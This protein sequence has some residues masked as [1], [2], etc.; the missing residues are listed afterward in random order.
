MAI[1]FHCVSCGKPIEVDDGWGGRLVQCPY[2]RDTVTAPAFSAPSSL[3]ATRSDE[4]ASEPDSAGATLPPPRPLPGTAPTQAFPAPN[5]S[6]PGTWGTPPEPDLRRGNVL[7][8]VAFILALVAALLGIGAVMGAMAA[9]ANAIG[10][11]PKPDEVGKFMEQAMQEGAPWVVKVSLAM[12]GGCGLW[13]AGAICGIIAVFRRPRGLAIA[14]LV[15]CAVPVLL[16]FLGL[17]MRGV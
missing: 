13:L 12:M 6:M 3:A 11:N 4:R 14:A 8:V 15:V 16:M 17:V 9:M 5:A 2:C 10:Q 1:Q 7:G